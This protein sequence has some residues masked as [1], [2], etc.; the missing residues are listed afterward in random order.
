MWVRGIPSS[1]A[2]PDTLRQLFA[3]HG[4]IVSAEVRR[5]SGEETAWA[6]LTFADI[7]AAVRPT[8][9]LEMIIQPAQSSAV[10]WTTRARPISI[11][12][13]FNDWI[14]AVLTFLAMAVRTGR[15]G[16]ETAHDPSSIQGR[17]QG[18][19]GGGAER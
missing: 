18:D 4:E 3:Q 1:H 6:L 12:I 11:S 5:K 2:E 16:R 13:A 8:T 10:I 17:R 14:C 19:G 15:R 9:T 7:D